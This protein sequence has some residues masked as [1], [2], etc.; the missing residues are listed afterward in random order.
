VINDSMAT[1]ISTLGA[2]LS[3]GRAPMLAPDPEVV[4]DLIGRR[5]TLL[6]D[7]ITR[8]AGLFSGEERGATR[9]GQSG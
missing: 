8:N 7:F 3:A 4:A 9:T 2:V 1:H 5:P 6:E